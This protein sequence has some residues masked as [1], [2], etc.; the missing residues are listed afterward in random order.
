MRLTNRFTLN[1][2]LRYEFNTVPRE[3][4]GLEA[5]LRNIGRMPRG[6]VGPIMVNNSLHNFSPRFGFAWTC[7]ETG[8]PLFAAAGAPIGN[9]RS[10]VTVRQRPAPFL[11]RYVSLQHHRRSHVLPLF[12]PASAV[13]KNC[14]WYYNLKQPS[15]QQYNLTIERQLPGQM[16]LSWPARGRAVFTSSQHEGNPEVPQGVRPTECVCRTRPAK[17]LTSTLQLVSCPAIPGQIPTGLPS[18]IA[19]PT[20]IPGTTPCSS[21]C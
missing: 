5:S 6:P 20:Q 13:R 18:V 14:S 12:F 15:M 2:G 1:L 17:R 8:E 16:V 4:N 9:I 10:L 3:V 7:L 19:R 21:A 11:R